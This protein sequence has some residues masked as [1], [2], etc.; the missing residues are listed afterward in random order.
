MARPSPVPADA[1]RRVRLIEGIEDPREMF[2]LDARPGVL[3]GD[4]DDV[5]VPRDAGG[6]RRARR[7]V[8][9]R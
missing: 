9:A 1:D 4:R 8:R 2:R 3:D 5:P 6:N 7:S